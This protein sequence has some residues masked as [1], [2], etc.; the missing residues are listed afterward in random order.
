MTSTTTEPFMPACD[1]SQRYVKVLERM[2]DGL[3]SFEFAIGWPELSVEL[4][5]PP[6]AFEEF[7]HVNRVQRL[8]DEH[9][10]P[11][12]QPTPQKQEAQG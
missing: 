5:L 11:N 3:V 7:C 4:L 2:P 12:Q 10:P 9:L 6:Q 8:D 1:P